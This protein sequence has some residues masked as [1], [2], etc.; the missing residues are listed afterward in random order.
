VRTAVV[1]KN[2]LEYPDSIVAKYKVQTEGGGMFSANSP[3][4]QTF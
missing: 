3:P 4:L 2:F 1:Q